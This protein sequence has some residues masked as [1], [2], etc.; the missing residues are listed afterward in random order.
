MGYRFKPAPRVAIKEADAILAREGLPS[1]ITLLE[2][3][4]HCGYI[5]EGRKGT[6]SIEAIAK[7]IRDVLEPLKP[8]GDF[9]ERT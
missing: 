6:P 7:R 9:A 1:Y 2:T 8:G 4:A 3:L 5:A